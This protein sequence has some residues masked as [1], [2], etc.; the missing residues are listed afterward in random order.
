MFNPVPIETARNM[1]RWRR[2]TTLLFVMALCMPIAFNAWNALLN[3]FVI[4]VAQFDGADIGLLHTV[5]EIPGFLAI[6]VIAVILLVREQVLGLVSLMLLGAATAV[7]AWFPSL[8]GILTITMLSSIGFHYYETVN[9]S[10]QLQWL[11]KARAPQ[12]LGWLLAAGSAATLVVYGLIVLL[13]EPLNLSYNVVFMSAGG[14]TTLLALVCLMVYPQFEAPHP[15]VKKLILRR[16]YWLY[17]ALQFMAGAR[18]QIF[19]VFA[20]FMMVEKFGFEV[21][22]VTALFLINLVINMT[23]A[24][25]LGRFVAKFGER[26]TLIF[27]YAGLAVVFAMYGGIYWFGWGVVLAATLYVIDHVLFALALAL[28]T[29]FQKIADPGDIAPT[30]AVAFTINHIAAVFLPVLLGLLWVISPAAVFGLAAAMALIS[31]TLACLIPRHPEP[32][33]ETVFSKFTAAAPA[34]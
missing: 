10:L 29:Y 28:K 30:A 32:G 1:L 23:V 2:P 19:V 15:Q 7:T 34:E 17:Y 3:N 25:L 27:E 5:R 26:R 21:H 13:W 8:G 33:N 31:L 20:G 22:E 24:P 18:R 6:G 16:R 12:I 11:P 9:Q 14:V 4:E